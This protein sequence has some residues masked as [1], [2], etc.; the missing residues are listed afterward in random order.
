MPISKDHLK[1]IQSIAHP[2]DHEQFCIVETLQLVS[3]FGTLNLFLTE[4]RYRYRYL[5]IYRYRNNIYLYLKPATRSLYLIKLLLHF[6][7]LTLS[8]IFRLRFKVSGDLVEPTQKISPPG[9]FNYFCQS[10]LQC[11]GWIRMVLHSLVHLMLH[12]QGSETI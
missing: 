9:D 3:F 4:Q 5:Q 1:R 8:L 2:L 7:A 11:G 10:F 12:H 6:G